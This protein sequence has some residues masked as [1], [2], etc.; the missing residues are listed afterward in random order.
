MVEESSPAIYVVS[1]GRGETGAEFLR[2][3]LVQFPNQPHSFHVRPDVRT[4]Y[5]VQAVVREAA[6]QR[7]VI[8]YTLVSEETRSAMEESARLLLIP[9]V[10]V[11]GPAF[12]ALHD[13]FQTEPEATHRITLERLTVALC[14]WLGG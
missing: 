9:I 13:L 11:L 5:E 4:R 10:D 7:A 14:R 1:D 8:F 12:S 3:A 6:R 2:A